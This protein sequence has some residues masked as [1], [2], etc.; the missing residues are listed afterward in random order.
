VVGRRSRA[1]T[2]KAPDSITGA[3][4]HKNS[5]NALFTRTPRLY[6]PAHLS[7]GTHVLRVFYIVFAVV[8]AGA[9]MASQQGRAPTAV[10]MKLARQALDVGERG[11]WSRAASIANGEALVAKLIAWSSYMDETWR[12]SFEEVAQF[13][14]KNPDW[15]FQNV[16]RRRAEETANGGVSETRLLAWFS[17]N[18]P[19]SQIGRLSLA[20]LLLRRGREADAAKWVRQSWVIAEYDAR[21]ETAFIDRYGAMLTPADHATRLDRLLWDGRI[22]DARRMLARVDHNHRLVGEARL[23]LMGKGGSNPDAKLQQV[24]VKLQDDPGVAYERMRLLRQAGRDD[25]ARE[26]ML[27]R[28]AARLGRAEK[29]WPHRETLARQAFRQG[30][31]R[32]AYR[33]ARDHG[34]SPGPDYAEAEWLAGWYALRFVDDPNAA[35]QHFMRMQDAVRYPVSKARGAYW[36]GRASEVLGQTQ[37]AQRWY[38]EAARH[39]AVYYGQLAA[40]RIGRPVLELPNPAGEQKDLTA[41]E[42]RDIVRATRLLAAVD[43]T[44]RVKH[45]MLRLGELA[46]QPGQHALVTRLATELNRPELAVRT[47]KQAARQGVVLPLGYPTIKFPAGGGPEVALLHA[48]SRQESEFHIEAVSHAGARGLM[49]LM[50][51]TAKEVA[52][53]LGLG[54]QLGWLT[55]DPVYNMTLGSAYLDELLRKYNGNY[56][57]ALAGY[58]AGPGRV[59]R[60]MADNGDPRLTEVDVIDWVEAIPIQETRNYVQ[61]V[62]ENL[63][64]YRA[65]ISGKPVRLTVN[66][67][68]KRPNGVTAVCAGTTAVATPTC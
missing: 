67:D 61:R 31:V 22:E 57:M 10:E 46:E 51:G 23:T 19:V 60:W 45:F 20:D 34:M 7:R 21:G 11:D 63:Q 50:P 1:A 47:A 35:L 32:E 53:K 17:A 55:S 3:Q 65:R 43:R 38:G 56:A 2:A 8:L 26:L 58:N 44:L 42:A 25:A 9:A 24:P 12:P 52:K 39:T 49:Q 36:A 48:L 62:I 14:E 5:V 33:L 41:F 16:L 15:P 29:W 18:P 13:V 40:E 4:Q 66:Q 68:L 64:V 6:H 59:Q 30:L 27:A 54:Y 37:A 28:G